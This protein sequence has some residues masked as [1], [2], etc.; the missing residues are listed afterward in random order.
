MEEVAA[1]ECRDKDERLWADQIYLRVGSSSHSEAFVGF[2]PSWYGDADA[3]MM[4]GYA[5]Q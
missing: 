3:V 4:V 5:L 2:L 1:S